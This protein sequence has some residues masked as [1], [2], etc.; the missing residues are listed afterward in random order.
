MFQVLGNVSFASCLH[1]CLKEYSESLSTFFLFR[2]AWWY[3]HIAEGKTLLLKV[4]SRGVT[5]SYIQ[6]HVACPSNTLQNI[7]WEIILLLSSYIWDL[8]G[9]PCCMPRL[10]PTNWQVC[11]WQDGDILGLDGPHSV[12]LFLFLLFR[13]TPMAFRSSHAGSE[14]RLWPT[15]QLMAMPDP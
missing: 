4:L 8:I 12:Y 9:S 11:A 13:A 10:G 2:M 7:N 5:S 3:C 14:L 6:L 15:P 1:G